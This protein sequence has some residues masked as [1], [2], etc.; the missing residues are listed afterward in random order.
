MIPQLLRLQNFLSYREAS[1]DFR[2]LGVACIAG[3]NGAGKSSLLE[4]IAWSIWGQGRTLTEDDVIYLGADEAQVDFTFE[5]QQQT[6]RVV[7]CRRRNQGGTLE[8]Q[9]KAGAYF[10][11]LTQRGM[12]ATQQLINQTLR[13][14]Y[15]TFVNSA[16]LRQGRADEFMLKRPSERKQILAE[17]LRLSQ[18]DQLAEKAKDRCREAK[19]QA[20]M[21]AASIANLETAYEQRS[22]VAQEFAQL[23]AKLADLQSWQT[24]TSNQ[25]QQLQQRQQHRQHLLQAQTLIQ[26][27]SA[28]IHADHLRLQQELADGQSQRQALETILSRATQIE[29]GIAALTALET[30]DE[31]LS[32]GQAQQA[33]LQ[34]DYDSLSNPY[35]AQLQAL[36]NQ[37]QQQ[38]FS[39][40]TLDQQIAALSPTLQQQATLTQALAD[41]QTARHQ[42]QLL[43]R[44]QLQFSPL[45]QQQQALQ[46]QIEQ[47][48]AQLSAR[49]SALKQTEGQ[50][51][52]LQAAYPQ[53]QQAITEV[54]QTLETLS[55]KRIYQEKVK[56]K[57]IER[58]Q[59][60]EQ[61]QAKQRSYELQLAQ[62][63]QMLQLL[64]QPQ[65]HCPL[66]DHS[67]DAAHQGTLVKTYQTDH[68]ELL[69]QIWAIREQLAVSEREIQVLR[70]EYRELETLFANYEQL[71]ERRGNLVA[72]LASHEEAAQTL[73]TL[74]HERS[75]LEAQLTQHHYAQDLQTELQ[76]VEA[77]LS[78]LNYDERDHALVRGQVDRLR[79]AEIRKAELQNAERK[80]E[81]LKTQRPHLLLTLQNLDRELTVLAQSETVQRLTQLKQQ[82]TDLGYNPQAHQ[83]LRHKLRA[84]QAWSLQY[85]TL[86]NARQQFQQ[87]AQHLNQVAAQV[88]AKQS[89]DVALQTKAR[90]LAEQLSRCPDATAEIEALQQQTDAAQLQR[91]RLLSQAGALEQRLTQLEDIAATLREQQETLHRTQRQG[92]IH[93]ELSQAFGRNGLQALIIE[94]VLPQLESETNRILGRLSAHQLHV[95]FVTQRLG[96]GRRGKLI[97]TLDILISDT[98]GTR[99]YDTY[100]GGEAF[101][102][103][104]AIRLALSQLLAQRAGTPLQM[105]I[106]DEGFGTQ[107]EAGCDRLIGAINAISP[108][109]A[110]ILA[111]THVP[112]F[113]EAFQTRIDVIKTPQGSQFVINA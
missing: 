99:P 37:Q 46:R 57:G 101:R 72:Q 78:Q 95:Q 109:F 18:Y 112:H 15:E 74:K 79:W 73:T 80:Y 28:H 53:V 49:L 51:Q 64:R 22:A 44:R 33:Q 14:D 81:Q 13:L 97:D 32:H 42:L 84:A 67:L 10:R 29:A 71:L 31:A 40:T 104:F 21:L 93:Q 110:C 83:A 41:L 38:Q 70:Q 27:Q 26:Q 59:F 103:N 76:Q 92:Q 94:H 105:L 66:C 48:Q 106:I 6:Y 47:S 108:D 25:L 107:D 82:I 50:L 75:R 55:T 4:A 87:L 62:I 63:D 96:R 69:Q 86:Q 52:K 39:L 12:R 7:R 111:V 5:Q 36:K 30:E 58:R 8:F 98:Q 11:S 113:R 23:Q 102:V 88:Q 77:K 65:A 20:A 56:E 34:A 19:A 45:K 90:T 61:L 89:E 43:E 3:A 9:V 2:G 24:T 35:Q 1:L 68:E 91:E 60:M 16:Y 54:G 100:S 85:Q 17:L